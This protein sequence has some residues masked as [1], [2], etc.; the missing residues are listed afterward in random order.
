MNWPIRTLGIGYP[1]LLSGLRSNLFVSMTPGVLVLGSVSKV[2]SGFGWL[3]WRE[4]LSV[5]IDES[6][7][8]ACF[9]LLVPHQ[10]AVPRADDQ[11]LRRS[12]AYLVMS[13]ADNGL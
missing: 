4:T 3:R 7:G 12:L 13:L 9:D 6:N 1:S 11:L 2:G 5:C 8:F 10:L